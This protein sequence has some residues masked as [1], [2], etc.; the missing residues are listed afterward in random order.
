MYVNVLYIL[1]GFSLM[2]TE[3][4]LCSIQTWEPT[5]SVEKKKKKKHEKKKHESLQYFIKKFVYL[6]I[7]LRNEF[8]VTL[9]TGQC[10]KD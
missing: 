7:I 3:V 2:S 4:P 8:T 6:L 9:L 1:K 10:K 5:I